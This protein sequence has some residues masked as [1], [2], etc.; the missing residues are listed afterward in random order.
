MDLRIVDFPELT[1]AQ[2]GQAA[3]AMR[4]GFGHIPDYDAP[5]QAEAEVATFFADPQR[6]ALAALDGDTLLGWIGLLSDTYPH[7]SELHPLVV[8]PGHQR[9]G[10][11]TALVHA[12]EARARSQG[13]LVVYL[14]TDDQFGGSSLFGRDLFPDV[15]GRIAGLR[16]SAGH[17][18]GF[19]R[20]LG[21]EVVGLLP[22]VNGFGK[23]DIFMA[24]RVC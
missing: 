8:D 22:D 21:Y 19:Y 1:A 13:V 20:K 15:A 5:G 11:G 12:L 16:E 18:F 3:D 24:K 6:W 10:V 17:P 7:G 14:G 23:P 9:R 2:R 4:A